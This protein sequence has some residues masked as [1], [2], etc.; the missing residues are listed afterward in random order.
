MNPHAV[1]HVHSVNNAAALVAQLCQLGAFWLPIKLKMRAIR[2]RQGGI[3][4]L[5][6]SGRFSL[7]SVTHMHN[8]AP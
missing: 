8:G 1:D 6:L 4:S 5:V 3:L 2:S 7:C